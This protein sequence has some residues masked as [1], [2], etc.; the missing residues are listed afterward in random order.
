MPLPYYELQTHK[1]YDCIPAPRC[2]FMTFFLSWI[3]GITMAKHL[4]FAILC[5]CTCGYVI[6]SCSATLSHN[7]L[8]KRLQLH[9]FLVIGQE[10]HT[11]TH[12][13]LSQTIRHIT[14]FLQTSQFPLHFILGP[15]GIS[16]R[17]DTTLSEGKRCGIGWK[18]LLQKSA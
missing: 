7:V 14:M 16:G 13:L 12:S 3:T 6:C 11:G 8:Q 2:G 9:S 4:H 10:N 18:K 5:L 17:R 1:G 15:M